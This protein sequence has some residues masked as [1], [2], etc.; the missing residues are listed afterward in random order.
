MQPFKINLSLNLR[1]EKF[2]NDQ[3]IFYDFN[4]NF[5]G[6]KDPTWLNKYIKV[7][8]REII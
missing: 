5:S 1:F 8:K 6:V 7:L 2:N 3:I 4:D